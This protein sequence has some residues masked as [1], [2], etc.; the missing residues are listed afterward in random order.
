MSDV[1][2]L[3]LVI[4]DEPQMRRFLKASLESHDYGLVEAVNAR[5]GLSQATGRN[6]DV[7]LLDLGLPDLDG[8]E[9]TRRLR[10]WSRTPIIVISARGREQDKIAALDAGADDYLTK[11]F[12]IGELLARLRVALRHAALP[13]GGG[14]PVFVVGDLKVD[15]AARLVFRKSAEVHLTPIEYK[16]LAT[17]VR[18]AGKV[19]THRQLLKEAWGPNAVEQTHYVRVYMTQLRHK[20]ED[21]PSRPK[22]LLTESG[23]GYR[24]KAE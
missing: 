7:I 10:E 17:L 1:A 22:V 18:H 8:I 15:L 14:E 13:D 3:V 21:D 23:V 5:E 16:L 2:P 12:G 24:L 20:L 6:P 9:L 4:E 11:P 19:V